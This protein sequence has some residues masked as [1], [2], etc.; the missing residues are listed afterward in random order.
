MT[1]ARNIARKMV[2]EVLKRRGVKVTQVKPSVITAA[3]NAMLV[4]NPKIIERARAEQEALEKEDIDLDMDIKVDPKL[5]AAQMQRKSD[6]T[7]SAKQADRVTSR[8]NR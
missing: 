4:S 6:K 2:K 7:L 5:V 3:A 8:V 1:A